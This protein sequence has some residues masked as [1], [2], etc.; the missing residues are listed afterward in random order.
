MKTNH[1]LIPTCLEETLTLICFPSIY[2][3]ETSNIKIVRIVGRILVVIP[4]LPWSL[5]SISFLFI[6]AIIIYS[7]FL[8][9]DTFRT[10]W[11]KV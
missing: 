11:D 1:G 7:L 8:V 6:V 4:M 5:F 2:F 9:G 10:W 3:T